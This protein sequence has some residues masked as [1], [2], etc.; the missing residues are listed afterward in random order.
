ML[1][2]EGSQRLSGM[3]ERQKNNDELCAQN[4]LTQQGYRDIRRPS[5]DPPDFVVDGHYAVEVT[6]LNQRIVVGDNKRSKG[7]EQARI[8]LTNCIEEIVCKLGP[9]GNE[10]RSWVIDCEYDFSE[11][12]PHQNVVT[13][14]IS[15]A[16]APLLKLYD[17]RVISGIHSRHL[18]YSKH[19]DELEYLN[20]P[21]LCLPCGICLELGEF[22]HSPAK[23]FLQNVSDGEGIG[24]AEELE[25]SIRNRIRDKS[26]KVRNQNKVGEYTNWWLVLVDHVC[27]LPMQI[28]SDHELSFIRDQKFD[29]WT[30]VVIVSSRNPGRHFDLLSR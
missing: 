26:K 27:H 22:S 17:D 20:Y 9:P 28:L 1:R 13:A 4:W 25:K 23:F 10:G 16:L 18:D 6:R 2:K 15:E 3:V 8:P 29:F 19:A 21:H 14:Q 12:L 5:D 30:R 11:P 24:I 7:E